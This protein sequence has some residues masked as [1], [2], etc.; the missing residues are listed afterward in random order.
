MKQI[1][2]WSLHLANCKNQIVNRP[3]QFGLFR[4]QIV[5][6][7]ESGGEIMLVENDEKGNIWL[8]H[9][10]YYHGNI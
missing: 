4:G 7:T 6:V 2:I 8:N 10:W 5:K 3:L 1:V 9:I